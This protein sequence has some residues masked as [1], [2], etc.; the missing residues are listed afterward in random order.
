MNTDGVDVAA[1]ENLVRHGVQSAALRAE[2]NGLVLECV[3]VRREPLLYPQD[4]IHID[5]CIGEHAGTDTRVIRANGINEMMPLIGRG[6]I[7]SRNPT[8]VVCSAPVADSSETEIGSI[9]DRHVPAVVA[10]MR[11]GDKRLVIADGWVQS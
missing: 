2:K 5:L 11:P 1:I 3:E 7:G 9:T 6:N 10:A 8:H 4:A